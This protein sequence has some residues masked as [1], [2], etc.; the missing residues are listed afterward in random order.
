M[1]LARGGSPAFPNPQ[2]ASLPS[3]TPFKQKPAKRGGW[4]DRHHITLK[5]DW[6]MARFRDYFDRPRSRGDKPKMPRPRLPPVWVLDCP[7]QGS[8]SAPD[9]RPQAVRH[10]PPASIDDLTYQRELEKN[11]NGQHHVVYSK[12]NQLVQRN[13]R[14]YFDRWKDPGCVNNEITWLL[15]REEKKRSFEAITGAAAR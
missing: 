6:Q 12:D 7:M 11:W 2:C 8:Q 5:N 9:I 13:Y 10:R 4:D 14:S 1:P 3:P 15:A